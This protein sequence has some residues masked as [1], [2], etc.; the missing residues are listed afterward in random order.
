VFRAI[1]RHWGLPVPPLR[2]RSRS[3]VYRRLAGMLRA[4][5]GSP[6]DLYRLREFTVYFAKNYPFGHQ[7]WKEVQNASD[8]RSARDL[9]QAF[10][11]RQREGGEELE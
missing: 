4:H 1:A 6:R 2:L 5:Y 9:A 8:L 7:L 10:F 11:T 3:A